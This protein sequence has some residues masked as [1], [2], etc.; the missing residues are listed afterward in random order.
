[1]AVVEVINQGFYFH[2]VMRAVHLLGRDN[3]RADALSCND[4]PRFHE[5]NAGAGAVRLGIATLVFVNSL[6]RA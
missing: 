5:A 4:Y 3:I 2:L 6:K 1:M